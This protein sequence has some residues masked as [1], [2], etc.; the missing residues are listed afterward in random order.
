MKKSNL[1]KLL[2][3]N[4]SVIALALTPTKADAFGFFSP[5][6]LIGSPMPPPC[7]VL[8][9]KKL[10]D[11]AVSNAQELQKIRETVETIKQ[12]KAATEGIVSQV[13][14]AADFNIDLGI[15]VGLPNADGLAG[16]ILKGLSG[17]IQGYA[18]KVGESF[19]AGEGSTVEA[20]QATVEKRKIIETDGIVEAYAYGT[21]TKNEVEET[22]ARFANLAKKACQSKDLRTD[23][24]V[25]SQIKMEMINLQAKQSYLMSS[26][27]R[28]QTAVNVK[29]TDADQP[30][31]IPLGAIAALVVAAVTQNDQ[32]DKIREMRDLYSKALKLTTSLQVV[33]MASKTKEELNLVIEQYNQAVKNTAAKKQQFLSASAGWVSNA[34]SSTCRNQGGASYV[35]GITEQKLNQMNQATSA[36]ADNS[37]NTLSAEFTERG[38][39][40]AELDAMQKNNVDYRFVIGGWAD[41][42]KDSDAVTLAKRMRSDASIDINQGYGLVRDCLKGDRDNNAYV[43]MVAG[44]SYQ[45]GSYQAEGTVTENQA[46]YVFTSGGKTYQYE[47]GYNDFMLEEAWKKK[48][49][50]EA[51]AQL[52]EFDNMI[53][54]ENQ[55]NKTAVTNDYVKGEL[56]GI[57]S[58]FNQLSQE[59]A[60]SND[61]GS[62]ERAAEISTQF[63]DNIVTKIGLPAVQVDTNVTVNDL[64]GIATSTTTPIGTNE[65]LEQILGTISDLPQ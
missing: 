21:I 35:V 60:S 44:K 20:S 22:N 27:L 24:L 59:V 15:D 45:I 65:S 33:E 54:Q 5:C 32:S 14:N 10:A 39:S 48:Y 50:E 6:M 1:K 38:I 36:L 18:A 3:F 16:P 62:K 56:A 25:N 57:V 49:A 19:Y 26:F 31:A 23:W 2:A 55:E 61:P 51:K 4:G 52:A 37:T 64:G 28:M 63:N 17:G 29:Q 13:R 41:P 47:K 11:V 9:Y 8:D 7:V 58:R 12:T 40:S 42:T 34:N 43:D 53:E 46:G 30:K